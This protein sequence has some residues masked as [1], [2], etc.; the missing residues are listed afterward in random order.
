MKI[1]LA[2]I[3]SISFSSALAFNKDI[4]LELK[5]YVKLNK[6]ASRKELA[7][8]SKQFLKKHPNSLLAY[9]VYLYP[10]S[11]MNAIRQELLRLKKER[12]KPL[13]SYLLIRLETASLGRS[14]N[15]Q[16][17]KEKIISKL[18]KIIRENKSLRAEGWYDLIGLSYDNEKK[19]NWAKKLYALNKNFA[20]FIEVYSRQLDKEKDQKEILKICLKGLKDK[21]PHFR[22]C[23]S[24]RRLLS[25]ENIDQN[26][27]YK[28][29]KKL[30][31]EI[32]E[33]SKNLDQLKGA[34]F[35]YSGL[36]FDEWAREVGEK[37]AGMETNWMPYQAYYQKNFGLRDFNDFLIMGKIGKASR[38]VDLDK[39]IKELEKIAYDRGVLKNL[40]L[41]ALSSLASTFTNPAYKDSD[42]ALHYLGKAIKID[43]YDTYSYY[44][45]IVYSYI[46]QSLENKKNL[47]K[48]LK[49]IDKLEKSRFSQERKHDPISSPNQKDFIKKVKSIVQSNNFLRGMAHFHLGHKKR[50]YQYLSRAYA[51]EKSRKA[52][53]YLGELSFD[54]HPLEAVNWYGRSFSKEEVLSKDEVERRNARLEKLA[55]VYFT[56][57]LDMKE[58][59]KLHLRD[60][61]NKK[62]KSKAAPHPLIGKNMFTAKLKDA[63]GKNYDWK[64]LKGSRVLVSFWAT[65]CTPCFQEMAV[66]NKI[67]REKKIKNLKV[68]GI[69]TDGLKSKK[70]VRK[71]LRDGK[72]DYDIVL[73]DGRLKKD[74]K[75]SGIPS[76]FFINE[77]GKIFDAKVGY[78]PKLEE[79]ILKKFK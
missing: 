11:G 5:E 24:V 56:K 55:K 18:E 68:V 1:I 26:K 10:R 13:F 39:K 71:I 27:Q 63:S 54:S 9:T 3:F 61:N 17:K 52:A 72:I 16:V 46:T 14:A 21:K 15:D 12:K 38:L 41:Y 69:C 59:K 28:E 34:Y 76:N 50:A 31:Q 36:S 67:I 19:R 42:K 70:K 32:A 7:Q 78:T 75:V 29:I 40:R 45:Y 48:V 23:R 43:A 22:Y 8:R 58:F 53:F 65:W 66:L 44:D 2:L 74:Y 30:A 6:S 64:K 79:I 37:T 73:S 25:L 57:P 77:K 33:N 62:E 35:F 51:V 60:H 4:F 49:L 20:P 47:K